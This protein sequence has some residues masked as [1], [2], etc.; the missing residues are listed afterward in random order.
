MGRLETFSHF[1]ISPIVLLN[2]FNN[3][4]FINKDT[5]NLLHNE[6]YNKYQIEIFDKI[7]IWGYF[8]CII[9]IYF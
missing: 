7:N 3:K 5:E 8:G 6:K 2:K 1:L 4:E 9:K